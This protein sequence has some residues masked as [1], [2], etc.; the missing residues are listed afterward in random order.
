MQINRTFSGASWEST[1]GYCRAVK[2]G[3]HIYVSGTAPVAEDGSVFAPGDAYAQAKRCFQIVQKALQDLD[4]DISNVVRT[5]M[6]VTDIS[7]W[8]EFGNAHQEFFAENPPASTMLEVKSL[9]NP[10]MLIEVEVDAVC[11]D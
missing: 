10:Q 2:A 5:R 11:F 6:Y 1:V 9:I 7:L 8:S 4:A 3:N